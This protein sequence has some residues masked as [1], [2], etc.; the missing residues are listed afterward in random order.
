MSIQSEITTQTTAQSGLIADLSRDLRTPLNAMIGFASLM[1]DPSLSEADRTRFID[2]ILGNGDQLLQLL[3]DAMNFSKLTTGESNV[4]KVRFNISEMVYNVVDA[5]KSVAEKKG[6]DIHVVF[7]TP[8]PQTIESDP[9]KVKQILA[10]VIGNCVRYAEGNGFLL[11]SICCDEEADNDDGKRRL[12]I[13]IDDSASGTAAPSLNGGPLPSSEPTLA[14]AAYLANPVSTMNSKK[15]Q[16]TMSA[17]GTANSRPGF[18]LSQK[19]AEALGGQL[20]LTPSVLGDGRAYT[21]TLP[22]GDLTGVPFLSKKKAPSVVEKIVRSFK[23]SNRLAGRKILLAEDSADNEI[24]MKFYLTKEGASLTYA[25]NGMEAVEAVKHDDFDLILMDI[26]MPL[27]DGLE[28]TRRIRQTGFKKP[29]IALTGHATRD[30][31][32]RSL[33]AGCDS[34]LTK[35]IAKETL[36]TEVQKYLNP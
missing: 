23:K 27:L 12:T 4:E 11:I 8:I 26:E 33:H 15:L 29:I 32:V 10:N 17:G 5:L 7:K 36:M 20:T 24:V 1:K 31:A 30:D 9:L 19:F 28:A 14:N 13:E 3:E 34:H 16:D 22:P 21:L 18:L 6:L 2:R 25:Q 35:P